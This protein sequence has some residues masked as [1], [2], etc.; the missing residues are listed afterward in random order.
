MSSR[1]L[2]EWRILV[3][4][5]LFFPSFSLLPSLTFSNTQ[6]QLHGHKKALLVNCAWKD[7]TEL[8]FY[9]SICYIH[10]Y[11]YVFLWQDIEETLEQTKQM[12]VYCHFAKGIGEPSYRPVPTWEELNQILVEALENYNE[13]NPAMNLVLFEDAMCHV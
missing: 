11:T 6:V 9:F 10:V 12:N 2:W 7:D 3:S 4:G 1:K 8:Y 5:L 13:V